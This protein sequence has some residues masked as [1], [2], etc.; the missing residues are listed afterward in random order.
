[1]I[2]YEERGR[3]SRRGAQLLMRALTLRC[4]ALWLWN[5]AILKRDS[6]KR[7]VE[8]GADQVRCTLQLSGHFRG[9]LLPFLSNL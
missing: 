6:V 2:Y 1:M 4:N 3:K 7:P 9:C 8:Y 5:Q